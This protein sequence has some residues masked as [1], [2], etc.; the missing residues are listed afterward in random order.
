MDVV[1][2]VVVDVS[3]PVVADGVVVP[4]WLFVVV[5]VETEDHGGQRGATLRPPDFGSG[6][7]P[8]GGKSYIGP[9]QTS[10]LRKSQA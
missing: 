5:P 9:L 7:P 1:V 2:V 6:G 10:C 8:T 3:V 4:W